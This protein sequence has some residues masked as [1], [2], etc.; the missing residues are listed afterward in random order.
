VANRR[1][2]TSTALALA[3]TALTAV[4][5]LIGWVPAV[6]RVSGDL[7]LRTSSP[8]TSAGRVAAVLIDD[9][10]VERLGPLPWPRQRLARLVDAV[11]AAG[12]RAVAIDLI[13]AEAGEA[14]GDAELARALSDYPV[15]LAAAIDKDGDWLL[16]HTDFGGARTAAHAYGEVGPDGVV[17]TIAATKQADEISLPAFSLAAARLLRPEFPVPSGTELRPEFRPAPQD[18]PGISAADMLEGRVPVAEISDRLVFIG[19]SA[20]G[21]GDQF[22]VPTGPGH[23]PVPGVLAHASAAASIL[24]GRLLR[25]LH[26]GWSLTAA[27]MLAIGVQLLRD[28]RGAFDLARFSFLIVGVG[29]IAIA[30]LRGGLVLIPV[31]ALVVPM[32]ISALLRETQESRLAHRETGR[33]LQSM[34]SHTA[35]SKADSVPRTAR[36]RLEALRNVQRLVLAEDATRRALLAG[37]TEGVVLWGKG[38]EVLEANPAASRLWGH[39]PSLSEIDGEAGMKTGE[40][41]HRRRDQREL[42]VEVTKLD[43]G[44][45]AII[46]DITAERTLERRRREMQRLV[47]HELKTPL[48]S[49]AGFGET[50]ERYQ[51]SG[52]ELSRVAKMIRGEAGRLQEMVTVFLDLE[53]LGAGHWAGEAEAVDFGALVNA[54]LEVLEAAA[55]ARGLTIT[56]SIPNS[57]RTFGV[58]ALLDRV[59]DNLVGNAIKYSTPGDGIEIEVR[60]KHDR[61]ILFVRDRGPGIPEQSADRIFDRFYRVPGTDGPGAGLGLALVKEVVDWHEGCISL[62][63]EPGVGSVFSVDLPAAEGE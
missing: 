26:P 50:L 7:L 15:V 9:L 29:A 4:A 23:A 55:G 32:I 63:S 42:S 18:I 51:L 6:D 33:L 22:I 45:L 17:R 2:L 5:W 3:A 1:W 13:L 21:A 19:I 30:A 53:R 46:R 61:V 34:I 28:R 48:A 11:R 37:M 57:V 20:T 8:R 58:P 62:D 56:S 25:R 27:F 60:R 43:S 40:Q 10:A 12:G 35:S 36:A 31:A 38:G 44:H 54:R 52:E 47:S 24:Q 49:I 16:P 39:V 41:A 14:D 59:V